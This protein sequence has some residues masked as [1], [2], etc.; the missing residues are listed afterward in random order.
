MWEDR[1]KAGESS[2]MGKRGKITNADRQLPTPP[3]LPAFA[4]LRAGRSWEE[5][6]E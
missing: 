1:R 2:Q 6:G 4:Q 5:E 3:I